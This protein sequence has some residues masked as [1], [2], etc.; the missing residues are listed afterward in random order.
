MSVDTSKET[1]E[2]M[3]RACS[4][5]GHN[6]IT[7]TEAPRLLRA[8]LAE[9]DAAYAALETAQAILNPL[10]GYVRKGDAIKRRSLD[11]ARDKIRAAL[12][13]KDKPNGD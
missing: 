1:V 10:S 3:A 8:L 7:A 2:Q 12:P 5:T 11:A 4:Q 9:R 13:I 6:H